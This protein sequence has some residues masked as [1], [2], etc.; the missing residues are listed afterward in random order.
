[1]LLTSLSPLTNTQPDVSVLQQCTNP[2]SQQVST[3]QR[4]RLQHWIR[5]PLISLHAKNLRMGIKIQEMPR[6]FPFRG[7][8]RIMYMHIHPSVIYDHVSRRVSTV[9]LW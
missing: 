1:M 8:P 6:D 7:C 9:E 3:L 5:L 4:W 2:L